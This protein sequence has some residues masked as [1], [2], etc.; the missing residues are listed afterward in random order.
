MA[1]TDPKT[2][3]S[4]TLTSS[5]MNTHVRDN[6]NYLKG[7]SDGAVASGVQLRR[8][9]DQ[10]IPD[11]T[12]T[13]VVFQQVSFELN[14][15]WWTSGSNITVPAAAVPAGFTTIVLLVAARLRYATDG[16]GVRRGQ[17]FLDGVN[18]GSTTVGALSADD[19]DFNILEFVEASAGQVVTLEAYHTAG[20]ALNLEVGNISVMRYAPAQ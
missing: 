13:P 17:L 16:D 18:F 7:T 3:A 19:T 4:E 6:L 1:W 10:S 14:G 15:D 5:D 2:W 12:A 11:A 9:S 20:G 8:T